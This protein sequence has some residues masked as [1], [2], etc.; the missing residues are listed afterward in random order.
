[1][2]LFLDLP[3]AITTLKTI[4]LRRTIEHELGKPLPELNTNNPPSP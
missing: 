2:R 1:M 4:A 3:S